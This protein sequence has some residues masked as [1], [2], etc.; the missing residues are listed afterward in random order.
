MNY[1]TAVMLINEEIR[2]I[3]C[4]Y[5]K[6]SEPAAEHQ[7]KAR[8]VFKTLDATIK[9]GDYLVVPTD[10]RHKM[11]VVRVEEVDVDVDFENDVPVNWAVG[12]VDMKTFNDNKSKEGEWVAKLKTVERKHQKAKLAEKVLGSLGV[13][14]VNILKLTTTSDASVLDIQPKPPA[15]TSSGSLS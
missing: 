4:S 2:A 3:S 11:T 5:E 8:T 15:D 1:T 12:K 9:K 13:D 6:E 10:T 14:D 7:I